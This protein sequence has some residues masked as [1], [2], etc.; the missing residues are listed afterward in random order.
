[1]NRFLNIPK[2]L[3]IFGVPLLLILAMVSLT[4]SS[5]FKT[6]SSFLS[7]A[8][9]LDLLLTV[10]FIYFLLIRKTSIPKTTVVP[11]I[12][13]GVVLGS[14]V[15]PVEH[16][17][18]LDLFKTW[19]LPVMEL[20]VLSYVVYNL[21]KTIKLYKTNK[22][23]SNLDFY[24]T[25]KSTC[26][27]ILPR[28][29]VIPVVT[30]IAV[31]YYGFIHW[32]KREL[33]PNEFSYHKNSGTIGLLAALIFLIA[34]ET[35]AIHLLLIKWSTVAAWILTGLSIYS[36]IQILGFLKSMTKRPIVVENDKLYL[37]YGIMNETTIS[38][39]N[40]ESIELSMKDIEMNKTTRKLSVLGNLE[41][42]NIIIK[43][44]K[45]HTLTGLYGV[46][47]PFTLIAFHVDNKQE[48]KNRIERIYK[49]KTV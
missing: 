18:Y 9:T 24:S 20:C 1:M 16:Q 6:H 22:A 40:I 8:I 21:V 48:F 23:H 42:H 15:I 29:A 39:D 46:K 11:F 47:K 49:T 33:K 31:F 7:T 4:F 5:Y 43:L 28:P 44:K 2:S 30:E 17:Y 35:A 12:I 14:F 37:R 19:A 3:I 13:L 26:A 36:G 45:E 27:E 41:G 34:I 32:K 10:P 38:F 25:L